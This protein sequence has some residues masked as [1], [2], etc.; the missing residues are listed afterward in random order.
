MLRR[1]GSGFA[2]STTSIE[3]KDYPEPVHAPLDLA[4]PAAQLFLAGTWKQHQMEL[5]EKA[6]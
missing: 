6:V 4:E 3:P 2:E 1:L 5:Q